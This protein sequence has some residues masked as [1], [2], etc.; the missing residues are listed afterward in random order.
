M[1][2]RS[3]FHLLLL[4]LILPSAVAAQIASPSPEVFRASSQLVVLDAT[5]LDKA[6][7]VVTQPLRRE[8]FIIEEDKRPQAIYSFESLTEHAAAANRNPEEL[9]LLIF[10]LDELN[11]S[12]QSSQGS[13]WNVMEQAAEYAYERNELAAFL[14]TQPEQLRQR[15]EV[16]VLTHHGYYVLGEP[17][18][19]RDA[20]LG[21]VT[22]H[23]PG[24]GQ[25]FRDYLEE[26]GGGS[27]QVPDYTLSRASM[28]AVWSLALRERSVPGRK[29]VVWLGYGGPPK[30]TEHPVS[31]RNLTPLQRH[32]REITDLLLDSRI[33]LDLVGPGGG[34]EFNPTQYAQGLSS[35]SFE[36]DFGFTGYISATGGQ[37]KNGNDIRGEIQTSAFYGSTFYTLSYR[38]SNHDFNGEFRRIHVRIKGHP[39][40]TVLTKQGYYAM[41]F[42]GE[43]DTEH[44]LQTD[45]EVAT[46]EAMPFSAVGAS[47]ASV[48]RIRDTDNALFTFRLDS[49][50]LQWR[51]GSDTN[52]READ[53][54]ISGAALGSVF[55][56]S[57]LAG[58][59]ATWKLSAPS[60]V[61]L[62][63]VRSQ[64]SVLLSV[65]PKTQRLRFVV[66]D[67]ANGRMGTI[68]L[69][70]AVLATAPT[71]DAPA[72]ALQQHDPDTPST[73]VSQ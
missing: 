52:C 48:Q 55:R 73:P 43:K 51:I 67:M 16:L 18:R 17:T 65:T 61:D 35:Y 72:P 10:V 56:N 22:R 59:V 33:T 37:W 12:Y 30:A 42:G 34:A 24:L 60:D 46:F 53:V 50:D 15:T 40:W 19:D 54:T 49:G 66:R 5:V 44:Q 68:D 11:Y 70:P 38:P 27:S 71:I 69:N 7:Q 25:P 21:K 58:K 31:A 57:A 23:N 28:S 26:S 3:R 64:I 47:L 6:G 14:R 45:M 41:Q 29:I 20:L 63:S 1:N 36:S 62:S 2:L 13:S 8:D 32:V 4:A 39:E 9:P